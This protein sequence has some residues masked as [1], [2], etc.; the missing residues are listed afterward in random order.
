MEIPLKKSCFVFFTTY[1]FYDEKKNMYCE[2]KIMKLF[3]LKPVHQEA[4]DIIK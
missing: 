4:G 2:K 3:I 1:F